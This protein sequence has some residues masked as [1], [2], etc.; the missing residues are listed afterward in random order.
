MTAEELEAGVGAAR[1]LAFYD[2]LPSVAE[3]AM[4]G[5]WRGSEVPSGHSLDGLLARSG[6]HGK[7]FDNAEAVHPL[8]F[9]KADGSRFCVDP[10]R[11]PLAL[12]VRRPG[13]AGRVTSPRLLALAAP[14]LA[15]TRPAA[16][17]R[18]LEYR[19]VVTATMLYDAQPI[20]DAFRAIDADTMLGAMDM[21]GFSAPYLFLLRREEA[22]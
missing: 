5:S 16:R 17:L 9:A 8:V 3:A 22:G 14:L 2:S 11:L 4:L 1:A 15:T 6:W 18:R 21:R 7:R 12:L 20:H 19:G 10:A 13:L